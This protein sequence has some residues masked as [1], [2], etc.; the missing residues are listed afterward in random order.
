M[1]VNTALDFQNP[2]RE[3]KS[4]GERKKE[5]ERKRENDSLLSLMRDNDNK[6]S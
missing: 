4:R 2:E 3:R 1:Q 5:S 6:S